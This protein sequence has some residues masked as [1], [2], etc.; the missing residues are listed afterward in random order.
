M[1]ATSLAIIYGLASAIIWG[2]GDFSGGLATKRNNVYIVVLIGHAVGLALMVTLALLFGE[3]IDRPLDLLW[4]ALAGLG[5]MVGV[6]LFYSSLARSSMGVV[7][8]IAAIATVVLPTLIGIVQDGFPPLS[9]MLGFLLALI[10][11][12]FLAGAGDFSA[13]TGRD[14]LLPALAGGGFALFIIFIDQVSSGAVFW[15][16]SAARLASV[17]FLSIFILLRQQQTKLPQ[18][19]DLPAIICSGLFD[20]GGN[21]FL[22]L[23]TQVGRLDIASIL[24]SLYPA[25]TVVLARIILKEKLTKLQLIGVVLALIALILIA[26]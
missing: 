3:S 12:W 8:P 21:T 25:S 9:T 18:V 22:A 7:A 2:A 11:I 5:G 16:L 13:I 4:G 6:L 24:S 19:R 10:A 15:P 23:A 26:I 1:P 20:A 14:L 17:S